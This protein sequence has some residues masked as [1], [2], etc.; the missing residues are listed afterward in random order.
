[1]Y[2]TDRMLAALDQY[3]SGSM[4]DLDRDLRKDMDTFI[5]GAA[6][7]DDITMLSLK[8]SGPL[9]EVDNNSDEKE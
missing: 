6:Q 2:G 3:S 7:F 9:A 1:M 4:E 8:Y 5:D